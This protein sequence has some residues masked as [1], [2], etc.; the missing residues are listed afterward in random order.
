APVNV[1]LRTPK[2]AASTVNSTYLPLTRKLLPTLRARTVLFCLP[3]SPRT[4]KPPPAH[5]SDPAKACPANIV[6]KDTK[7]KTPANGRGDH[8]LCLAHP[9]L[10]PPALSLTPAFVFIC[11]ISF[12]S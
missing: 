11:S 6:S 4:V 12:S 2:V 3:E 9:P 10:R 5:R 7:K 8:L 1:Q